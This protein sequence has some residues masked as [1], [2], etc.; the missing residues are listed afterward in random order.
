M[1]RRGLSNRALSGALLMLAAI[2]A[3]AWAA[4]ECTVEYGYFTGAGP[5][6]QDRT[7]SVTMNAGQTS[8]IN[9]AN[10]NFVRSSGNN[11]VDVTLTGALN[12]NFTLDKGNRNPLT[13]YYLTPT[14][15]VRLFCSQ[16]AS[17]PA[18]GSPE[19]LIGALKQANTSVNEIATQLKNTFNLTG[20]QIATLLRAA[21]YAGNQV[22]AALASTFNATGAQVAG[23]M[24]AAG[25][26]GDQVAAALKA[27]F[28][29]TASQVAGWLK[30]AFNA[31][32]AQVA[33]WLKAAAYTGEQV[34]AA[35][36]AQFNA[37]S[38]Q[39]ATWLKAAFNATTQ[40]LAAWLR[41]AGYTLVQVAQALDDMDVDP[42]QALAAVK[43]AFNA[44]WTEVVNAFKGIVDVLRPTN[45]GA[46]GCIDGAQL[47]RAAGASAAEAL[48]ALKDVYNLS[49]DAARQIARS[50]F[51][52]TGAALESALTA[53]GY[54]A[55]AIGGA[56]SRGVETTVRTVQN[57]STAGIIIDC[58]TWTDRVCTAPDTRRPPRLEH[59]VSYG[60]N[61]L[62]FKIVGKNLQGVTGI[63]GLPARQVNVSTSFGQIN[64]A[65]SLNQTGANWSGPTS[66]RANLTINGQPVAGGEFDWSLT[67]GRTAPIAVPV[68]GRA[69]PAALQ[70]SVDESTLYKLAGGTTTDSANNNYVPLQNNAPHCQT[71]AAPNP[72]YT[73]SGAQNSN[74]RTINVGA[75]RWQV[76]NSGST[77]A[78]ATLELVQ[79]AQVLQSQTVTVPAGQTIAL[80]PHSRAQNQTCVARLGADGL[81]YHCGQVHEGWNDNNVTA[82]VRP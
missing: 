6:R 20:Q 79:G 53:A 17:A 21:G 15:L 28:N 13:G 58:V 32:G 71:V 51:G 26:A 60:S 80:T 19:Q 5:T 73:A 82:R 27:Q 62:Q 81:C 40:Q 22:A 35:L 56:I 34:A 67:I 2:G 48:K 77:A 36:K 33:A 3:P 16:G 14:T 54:A 42:A 61:S 68:A 38:T 11:K 69:T 46:A 23:W 4:N 41:G 72:P 52:L 49:E 31:T 43:Q 76:R 75:I 47:L 10:L 65:A 12:N 44:S 55:A 78:T 66:G 45:C 70:V 57:P 24:Q 18:F 25:Y 39:V 50:V 9:R 37:T 7:T 30:T 64:V 74:R 63:S 8:T 59:L 1:T 29:A